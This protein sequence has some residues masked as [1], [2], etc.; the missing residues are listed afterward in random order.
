MSQRTVSR[1]A[2]GT[3]VDREL[4]GPVA[5]DVGA[6]TDVLDEPVFLHRDGVVIHCNGAA[7]ALVGDRHLDALV[8]R[9]LVDAVVHAG[10]RDPAR[11]LITATGAAGSL[12]VRIVRA[13]GSVSVADLITIPIG[14]GGR[15]GGLV[16]VRDLDR[17]P[18]VD[19][20]T[21]LATRAAILDRLQSELARS[22]RYGHP[23]SIALVDLDRFTEV[24]ETVGRGAGDEALRTAAQVLRGALRT[25][26]HLGRF[27]GV[28]FLAILTE[29]GAAGAF[30]AAERLRG[31][32]ARRV[33][34][35][36]PDG[37]RL[38]LTVSVG[39]AGLEPGD[40]RDRLLGRAVRAL[41]QAKRSGRDCIG[42]S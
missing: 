6:L 30:A 14:D 41:A 24:N 33:M 39:V 37:R 34:I 2:P 13:D 36:R 22:R 42:V 23:L 26:D 28:R 40:D 20:L 25:M 15:D 8:G 19:P 1:R 17:S 3:I 16:I 31:A 35:E 18:D 7:A 11:R 38:R 10:D 5:I 32:A 27:G 12:E 9:D 21:G 4:G 29:V